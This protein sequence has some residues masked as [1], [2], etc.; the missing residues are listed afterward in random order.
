[1][2]YWYV[3]NTNSQRRR[4]Y[5]TFYTQDIKIF[6]F[7]KGKLFRKRYLIMIDENN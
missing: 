1:M 6:L 3:E 7:F 2:L 5:K 4:R